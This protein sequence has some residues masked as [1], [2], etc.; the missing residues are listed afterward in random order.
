M[1][2]GWGGL[3]HTG[4]LIPHLM[5]CVCVFYLK[6]GRLLAL[7]NIH[8]DFRNS[9]ISHSDIA[10]LCTGNFERIDFCLCYCQPRIHQ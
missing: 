2:A 8:R 6:A 1:G 5:P 3:L 7:D 9:Q 4:G 10:L